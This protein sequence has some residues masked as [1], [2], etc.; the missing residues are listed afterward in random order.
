M[1]NT[2]PN[3]G[4]GAVATALYKASSVCARVGLLCVVSNHGSPVQFHGTSCFLCIFTVGK[5]T[6]Y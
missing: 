5:L 3:E 6:L 2:A 4:V 1:R